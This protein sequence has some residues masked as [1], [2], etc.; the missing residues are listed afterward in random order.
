MS[1]VYITNWNPAR[2]RFLWQRSRTV[3]SPW[4]RACSAFRA[5]RDGSLQASASGDLISPSGPSAVIHLSFEDKQRA[6]RT[7]FTPGHSTASKGKSGD[8]QQ[9][10]G[11]G[12]VGG[13]G[14]RH[15]HAAGRRL[16]RAPPPVSLLFKNKTFVSSSNLLRGFSSV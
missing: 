13:G 15:R 4:R 7:N 6:A 1:W 11:W 9:Q 8:L 3:A 5:G 14:A 12:R 2:V 10:T 16:P